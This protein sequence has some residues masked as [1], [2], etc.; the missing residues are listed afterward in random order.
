MCPTDEKATNG[1]C[2]FRQHR[3]NPSFRRNLLCFKDKSRILKGFPGLP[4]AFGRAGLQNDIFAFLCEISSALR[5]C[6][7]F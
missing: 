5:L 7:C 3:R 2:L 1:F 6:V 4:R